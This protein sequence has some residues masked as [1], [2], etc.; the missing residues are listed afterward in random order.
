VKQLRY[1]LIPD[2]PSDRALI[3]VIN[4]TIKQHESFTGLTLLPQFADLRNNPSQ[5]RT[6]GERLTDAIQRFPCDVLFIHRDAEKV[7]RDQ[8]HDEIAEAIARLTTPYWGPVIPVR[9]TEAW[10]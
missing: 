2:G 10:L 7:S 5:S 1:T 9:M 4:W 3:A 8:R 6:L